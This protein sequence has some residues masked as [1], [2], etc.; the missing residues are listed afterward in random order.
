MVFFL[1]CC[2]RIAGTVQELNYTASLSQAGI[3]QRGGNI[4]AYPFSGGWRDGIESVPLVAPVLDLVD[5]FSNR[6][7]RNAAALVIARGS[8]DLRPFAESQKETADLI[9]NPGIETLRTNAEVYATVMKQDRMG[10]VLNSDLR[11]FASTPGVRDDLARMDLR[12]VLED[13]VKS[14]EPETITIPEI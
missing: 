14:L 9:V 12:R 1:F 11:A 13:F 6:A 5:P 10:L 8:A 2:F 3:V 4:P 7:N